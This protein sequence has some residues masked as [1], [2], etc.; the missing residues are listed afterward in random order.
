MAK[1]AAKRRGAIFV[2]F[3]AIFASA[4][5][6]TARSRT[7]GQHGRI[8]ARL[9]IGTSRADSSW[10]RLG[11]HARHARPCASC[12]TMRVMRDHAR[13]A[14]PCATMRTMRMH[15]VHARRTVCNLEKP[16]PPSQAV[17]PLPT[18]GETV[19]GQRSSGSVFGPTAATPFAATRF[20][21]FFATNGDRQTPTGSPDTQVMGVWKS[22]LFQCGLR[23]PVRTAGRGW[24]N[25]GS[26]L[27]LGND[28]ADNHPVFCLVCTVGF[29]SKWLSR[30]TLKCRSDIY[31]S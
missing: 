7:A 23:P 3:G 15:A 28:R 25:L 27:R 24:Q 9:T 10:H 30:H 22:P 4:V 21:P 11:R 26:V 31:F 13:H 8:I 20:R 12:A 1:I 14:R 6:T 5:V 16:A 19:Q 29:P 17:E 2:G 18:Q